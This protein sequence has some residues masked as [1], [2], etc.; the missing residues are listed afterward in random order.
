MSCLNSTLAG[1]RYVDIRFH[2]DMLVL[3][4]QKYDSGAKAIHMEL[5]FISSIPF[6]CV[7]KV[8]LRVHVYPGP[9][10]PI[11]ILNIHYSL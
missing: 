9:S 10:V 6:N 8:P 1:I 2:I 7:S 4:N 11:L 5:T 3:Q